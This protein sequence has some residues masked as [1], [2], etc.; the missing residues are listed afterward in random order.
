LHPT[1]FFDRI[2][3]RLTRVLCILCLVLLSSYCTAPENQ[4]KI[5]GLTEDETYLVRAYVQVAQARDTHR[6]SHLKAESLFA[7]IDSTID[8]TR[9]ANTID[10][11]NRDPERWLFVFQRIKRDLQLSLERD[12]EEA[13]GG[14]GAAADV[15]QDHK[16]H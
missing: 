3:P 6:V 12:S 16:R 4:T 11:L 8:T 10:E 13:R 5:T 14:S 9:I 1:V 7:S 15:D 2:W